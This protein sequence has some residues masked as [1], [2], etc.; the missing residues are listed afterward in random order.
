MCIERGFYEELLE[1]PVPAIIEG[2]MLNE[3]LS[4]LKTGK[5]PLTF[6]LTAHWRAYLHLFTL[7]SLSLSNRLHIFSSS[8]ISSR[9]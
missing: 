8:V 7:Q 1:Q 6:P 4:I 9:S 5:S 2:D 3:C